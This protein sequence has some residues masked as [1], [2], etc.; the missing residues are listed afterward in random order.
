ML[1]LV[2]RLFMLF[3]LVTCGIG[4][5]IGIIEGDSGQELTLAALGIVVF[6]MG[7]FM[8]SKATS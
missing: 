7:R 8:E 1:R 4:L 3:G 6:A 2:G 5:M